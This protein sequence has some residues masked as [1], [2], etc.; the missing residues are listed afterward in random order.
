VTIERIT[1]AAS[2]LSTQ[3]LRVE[4]AEAVLQKEVAMFCDTYRGSARDMARKLGV[5]VAYL[6]DIRHGRRKVSF[7]VVEKLR[8]LK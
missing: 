6:C 5:S 4:N 8:K 7:N 3:K 2:V 1:K